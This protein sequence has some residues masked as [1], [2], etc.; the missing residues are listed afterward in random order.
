MNRTGSLRRRHSEAG[1]KPPRLQWRR[2]LCVLTFLC[3]GGLLQGATF[4]HINSFFNL[5][6]LDVKGLTSAEYGI[7]M[8]CYCFVMVF[9]TPPAAKL[10]NLKLFKDKT[11]LFAA[12]TIDAAFC[13]MLSFAHRFPQGNQFFFGS[14]IIR[15]LEAVGSAMGIIMLY[16][17]TGQE[18]N[19]INHI[20]IPLFETIHGISVVVSPALGGILYD[21]GGFPMPFWVM[22]GALLSATMLAV[23]FFPEH[24][25][26]ASEEKTS[27]DNGTRSAWKLPVIVNALSSMSA[28]VLISFNESTLARQL[29]VEF[30]MDA[31]ESGML[32]FYAG[33]MYAISSLVFGFL[34]KKISDPRYFVLLGLIT[35]I[36][37][38]V[39]L[40]PL[41]P[42]KQ[43]KGIVILSQ[44]LLGAGTGPSF[45]CSY[46]HSLECISNGQNTKWTYAALSAIF[47][48][49]ASIG[50]TIGPVMAGMILNNY[51]FEAVVAVNALQTAVMAL[52]LTYTI[53]CTGKS[54]EGLNKS[55]KS[56]EEPRVEREAS[57]SGPHSAVEIRRETL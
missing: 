25:S 26:P 48:P 28:Y 11:I 52:L 9:V 20:V 23:G 16:V 22:G 5:Y 55:R 39:L 42:V 29:N 35:S 18:L 15:I 12:W 3:L 49:A 50:C 57:I 54:P 31:T 47:T 53:C 36:V 30:G 43:T 46:M 34:S 6:A 2:K 19:D 13:L 17:I 44:V 33:G 14:L 27:Q 56:D 7:I 37:A 21:F 40:G 1:A 10:V 41:V 32:F 4:S 45:V 51:P 38:L 8:G 24:V